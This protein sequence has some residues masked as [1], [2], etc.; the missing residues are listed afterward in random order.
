MQPCSFTVSEPSVWN[1]LPD[2]LRN[3]TL[4]TNVLKRD[5]NFKNFPVCSIV[6]IYSDASSAY[7]TFSTTRYR[8]YRFI[9]LSLIASNSMQLFRLYLNTNERKQPRNALILPLLSALPSYTKRIHTCRGISLPRQLHL[10]G[11][12]FGARFVCIIIIII[13]IYY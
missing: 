10:H 1:N 3:P 11:C 2:L 9:L 6:N 7:I 12:I 4:S 13:I 5:L 8:A